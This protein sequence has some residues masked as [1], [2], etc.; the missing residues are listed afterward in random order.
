MRFLLD[1][2]V[3]SELRK[4]GRAHPAVLAW[5]TGVGTSETCASA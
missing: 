4:G 3:V 5:R 2:N 1:T